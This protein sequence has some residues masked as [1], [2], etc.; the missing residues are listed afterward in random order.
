MKS[1][2]NIYIGVTLLVIISIVIAILEAVQASKI[3]GGAGNTCKS[4]VAVIIMASVLILGIAIFLGA[5]Q[6]S[7]YNSFS[8]AVIKYLDKIKKGEFSFAV[9]DSGALKDIGKKVNEINE[10][11]KTRY[12]IADAIANGDLSV[13]I[14]NISKEDML[15]E[16]FIR[17]TTNYNQVLT[18][19]RESSYMMTEEAQ[20]IT[21]A[22]QTLAQGTTQ[23]A[24]AIEQI[25]ASMKDIHNMSRENATNS[26][27]ANDIV[28][29]TRKG[30]LLGNDRMVEMKKAMDEIDESSE[31]ISKIIKVIDDISFQTNILALNAAVEAARAG[32][33]GKGFAVVAEQIRELAGR[34]ANAAAETAEMIEDSIRKVRNGTLLAEETAKALDE[35]ME[36]INSIVEI[37]GSINTASEEQAVAVEQIDIAIEQVSLAIQ[38]N[39]GAS[40]KCAT[41]AEYLSVQAENI[42]NSVKEYKLKNDK[43]QFDEKKDDLM[44]NKK[45]KNSKNKNSNNND[46]MIIQEVR[47]KIDEGSSPEDIISLDDDWGKY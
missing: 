29:E 28:Q 7:I 1:E 15:G 11:N 2:K 38:N 12:E 45:N 16:A 14:N 20:E 4:I 8:K 31:K 25:S 22:S 23:Q 18:E 36:N 46:K 24:S 9:K 42:R 21:T 3:A 27:K 34:S 35:I 44:K 17:M 37:T 19:V 6:K 41:T 47:K 30:A 33:H 40:E 26:N 5:S 39:S 32:E 10:A 43:T 13:E